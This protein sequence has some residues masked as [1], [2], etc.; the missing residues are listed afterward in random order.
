MGIEEQTCE[1]RIEMLQEYQFKV[2]FSREELEPLLMDEPQ[3]VGKG[4]YPNAGLLLAAA[5]GNCLASS[6]SFCLRRARVELKG[7]TALVRT[8]VERNEK[9]RLRITGIEVE[10]M[11]LVGDLKRFEICRDVFEDFCIVTESIRQ[12]IPVK[13]DVI[14]RGE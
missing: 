9:G 10:L 2:S 13:V 12:G 3:P 11:P 6:L 4:Q 7:M 1:I 5:T 14:P 8:K